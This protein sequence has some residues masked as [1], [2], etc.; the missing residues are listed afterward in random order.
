[1]SPVSPILI[2]S[3]PEALEQ[4]RVALEAGQLVVAPTETRY[5]LLC[6]ADDESA[7]ERL[8]LA[9]QRPTELVSSVFVA[10]VSEVEQWARVSTIAG[11]LRD[12]FLPGP[13]TLVLSANDKA[14]S[15]LSEKVI[16]NREIGIRVSNSDF[17]AKLSALVRFPLTATSANISGAAAPTSVTE[18][19]SQLGDDI[20]LYID[21][22]ELSGPVSTVVRCPDEHSSRE[23]VEVL[24]EGAVSCAEIRAFLNEEFSGN[25]I[26]VREL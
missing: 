23:C 10:S 12:H 6:R 19:R 24:R 3:A 5:G 20:S 14:M 22:G 15:V 21:N 2:Q 11:K 13:M 16:R 25:D 26:E 17:I 8:Y 1:M 7:L 18:I 9:K 4:A